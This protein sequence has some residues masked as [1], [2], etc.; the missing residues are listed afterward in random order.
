MRQTALLN[1]AVEYCSSL[2]F[3]LSLNL[4]SDKMLK[5]L[6]VNL[7]L[8]LVVHRLEKSENGVCK[9]F[10][11]SLKN[12][13]DTHVKTT[14]Y[15]MEY[16][17]KQHV[18]KD[19]NKKLKILWQM[20]SNHFEKYETKEPRHNLDNLVWEFIFAKRVDRFDW[21]IS[22][23]TEYFATCVENLESVPV[24]DVL[25]RRFCISPFSVCMDFES[26]IKSLSLL[27]NDSEF[28]EKMSYYYFFEG[29]DNN[30][31]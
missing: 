29:E 26:K 2:E 14:I 20:F 25:N 23:F 4:P 21:R 8:W 11:Y 27:K 30:E 17:K 31:E 15:S 18:Y 7:H 16:K 12:L 6:F 13:L 22:F 1:W 3:Q 24:S 28:D 5:L 10:V 19:N 9:D